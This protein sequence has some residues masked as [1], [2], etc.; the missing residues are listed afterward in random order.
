MAEEA[1]A[2]AVAV[3]RL[4][5]HRIDGIGTVLPGEGAHAPDGGEGLPSGK[6]PRGEAP[7]RPGQ[8]VLPD[9]RRLPEQHVAIV[10]PADVLHRLEPVGHVLRQ[11]RVG[12]AP[13][14]EMMDGDAVAALAGEHFEHPLAD[15]HIDAAADV[16]L[17]HRVMVP[18]DRNVAVRRNLAGQPLA[19]LPRMVGE[20]AEARARS[21]ASNTSRRTTPFDIG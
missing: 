20:A 19:P 12:V 13:G 14:L 10:R 9:A 17:G 6:S 8:R 21:P 5:A 3:Q 4:G 2:E 15:P 18:V 7:L 11:R 1:R 16:A